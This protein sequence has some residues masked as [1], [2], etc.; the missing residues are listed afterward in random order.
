MANILVIEFDDG[1]RRL[2]ESQLEAAGHEAVPPGSL[3]DCAS[4][5]PVDA[6]V[7]DPARSV[8]FA[9]AR[10]LREWMPDLPFVF[11]STREP[12]SATAAL[13][14]A[15]HLVKPIRLGELEDAL[16]RALASAASPA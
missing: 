1:V 14:P 4:G 8:G 2:L 9:F 15:A 12:T 16:R 3:A 13:R 6:A 10:L 11:L 5:P 7:V